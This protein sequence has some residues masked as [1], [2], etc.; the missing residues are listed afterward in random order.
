MG[1]TWRRIYAEQLQTGQLPQY[2]DSLRPL[3]KRSANSSPTAAL[4]KTSAWP[5]PWT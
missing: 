2:Y 5:K 3:P 1:N 4:C